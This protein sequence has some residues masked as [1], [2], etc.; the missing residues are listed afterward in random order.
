MTSSPQA[1]SYL[2]SGNVTTVQAQFYAVHLQVMSGDA[3]SWTGQLT[4]C[5]NG[6]TY[7]C[8]D[9]YN[10]AGLPFQIAP[11]NWS[12]YDFLLEAS[13]TLENGKIQLGLPAGSHMIS[14]L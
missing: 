9:A 1:V 5:R 14:A 13:E 10:A 6:P 11:S 4:A 12:S 8:I 3:S 2:Y 7:E